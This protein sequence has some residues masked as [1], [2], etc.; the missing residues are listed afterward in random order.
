MFNAQSVAFLCVPCVLLCEFSAQAQAAS[1]C[2]QQSGGGV[3][4][5]V[6]LTLTHTKWAAEL[7]VSFFFLLSVL[8]LFVGCAN[9]CACSV[10]A[11][12]SIS[13]FAPKHSQVIVLYRVAYRDDNKT[14]QKCLEEQYKVDTYRWIWMPISDESVD[15]L[16]HTKSLCLV[17]A[18]TMGMSLIE[19]VEYTLYGSVR[20]DI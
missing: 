19:Q 14:D 15:R 10:H 3:I 4:M 7:C 8:H 20:A 2:V 12:T 18:A 9:A 6:T 16:Q 13:Q 1:L 17:S 5:W 11:S